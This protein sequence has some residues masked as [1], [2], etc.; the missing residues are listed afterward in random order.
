MRDHYNEF[1]GFGQ[2]RVHFN[3]YQIGLSKDDP[4]YTLINVLEDLNY[5][6]LL[7]CYSKRGRK[8]YNPIMI[9]GVIVYANMQ[10]I[11]SVDRIVDLCTRDI[12]F[13]WLTK[14]Q[15]PKRDTFYSFMNDKV[16]SEIMDKLHYQ[17][18][19]R[20]CEEGFLTLKSL[21]ID[22]TKI[23]ANANRYTF[24]WRGSLNYRLVGLL[25][26]IADLYE[27][28]NGFIVSN[29]Y[30]KKYDLHIEEMFIISGIDKIR[31]VIRKNKERKRNN[32]KKISNNTLIQIQNMCPLSLLKIQDQLL[33]ISKGEQIYFEYGKGKR[34][35]ELQKLYE[36]LD[37]LGSRIMK[38]K[39]AFE[40]LGADRNSYSKTDLEATFMRMKDDHMM[41]G[42]LKPA[43][44]VQVAVENYF[45]VHVSNSA[46]RTD[47]KTL[48]PIIE[49]H[50]KHFKELGISLK[51][52]T[53][54]S[55]YCSESNLAYLKEHKIKSYIKLQ[56]HE[57]KKTKHYH[58]DIGKHYNMEKKKTLGQDG[59]IKI[60]YICKDSR[61]LTFSHTEN[62]NIQGCQKTYH[63]YA[64][65]D[66]SGCEFKAKCL[67][68]YDETR[69]EAK[70]K[71]M[72]I[73]QTWEQ[74]KEESEHNVLS[75]KGILNR[76][77]RSIQTEGTFGDMKENDGFRRFNHRS[78]EKVYKELMF[79]I[80]GRN[81]NK[82]H[83]FR[84]GLIEKFEGK[85]A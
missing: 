51:E 29:G 52:V 56:E 61:E 12:G 7:A 10:G 4:V 5:N 8:G 60:S 47:Y 48:I 21:F 30:D 35:S 70:N 23:E 85:V 15:K 78:K 63:V 19:E 11:R 37:L 81:I 57:K 77:I 2:Q 41:N 45:T 28:Y 46:D 38:Y 31:E 55:G 73:N 39:E 17:F 34:K 25:D 71:V 66:C 14:G 22:G 68:K 24:V 13:I 59:E 75:E 53:A 74:L 72:K 80:M 50:N 49:K 18:M 44:N 54:D 6:E 64:C 67:Y 36:S 62:Q 32:K 69:H 42:Q 82:Y 27:S 65:S 26:Q 1:F 58:Q 79:Y 43:Y 33:E 83:R 16:T 20:L 9:Y 3:L 84:H 76:Q 40:I